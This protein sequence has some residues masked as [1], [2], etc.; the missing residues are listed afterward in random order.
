MSNFVVRDAILPELAATTRDEA[1]REMVKSLH[2]AGQFLN[3]D[4]D[5]IVKAVIRRECLGSTGIGRGIA[6]P[7]SRHAS[8][9]QLVGT[10]AISRG[11]LPFDSIDGEP[12][13]I[14]VLLIS[15]QD[16]PG[17]HLRALEN[18]VQTMRDDGF[19]R[20]VRAAASRDELW[21]LLNGTRTGW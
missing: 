1:I 4:L 19:V 15:P 17:D 6:I 9:G 16:R 3:T 20:A 8:V 18:V 7:H 12:V 10:L 13:H 2:A 14:L 11:G 21:E 5:D